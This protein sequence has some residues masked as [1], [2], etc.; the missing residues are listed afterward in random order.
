[1]NFFIIDPQIVSFKD[2]L[3]RES[4]KHGFILYDE[5]Q[6]SNSGQRIMSPVIPLPDG[7]FAVACYYFISKG[8]DQHGF[9]SEQKFLGYL[10][11][12]GV[13]HLTTHAHSFCNVTLQLKI[14]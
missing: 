5:N 3:I 6:F 7:N 13:A 11:Q 8:E 14:S 9:W 12:E 2:S 10:T 4:L 1:M